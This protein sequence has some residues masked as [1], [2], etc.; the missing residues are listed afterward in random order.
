LVSPT[1]G[2]Y[3][4]RKRGVDWMKIPFSFRASEIEEIYG[5]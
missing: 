3:A 1:V 2:H 4:R 5:I